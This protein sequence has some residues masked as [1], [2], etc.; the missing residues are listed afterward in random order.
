MA[1]YL[2]T[3]SSF[4][5]C[6]GPRYR[7]PHL[8]LLWLYTVVHVAA[9]IY[10]VLFWPPLLAHDLYLNF[11]LFKAAW[12]VFLG[13]SDSKESACGAADAGF[14]PGLGRS[15]REG[16]SNPLK[17]SCLGNPMD[18]GAWQATVHGVAQ[19]DT[20]EQLS[21]HVTQERRLVFGASMIQCE[22]CFL[23]GESYFPPPDNGI[24]N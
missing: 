20:T 7:T 6:L 24:K 2:L 4:Q 14:I 9:D 15:P 16:N 19:S 17:Y 12:L 5:D 18:R 11:Q 22:I 3:P 10:M 1:W 21:L 23:K 8:S 13:G